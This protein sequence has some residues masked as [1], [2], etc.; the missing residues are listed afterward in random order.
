[1]RKEDLAGLQGER[2]FFTLECPNCHY[3]LEQP[4]SKPVKRKELHLR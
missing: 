1:M 4:A 2:V 3:R